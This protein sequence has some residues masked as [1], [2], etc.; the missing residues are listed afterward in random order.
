MTQNTVPS[1]PPAREANVERLKMAD[2]PLYLGIFI[3]VAIGL[4]IQA[5]F[6]ATTSLKELYTLSTLR[7]TEDHELAE[8]DCLHL[9][10]RLREKIDKYE[11]DSLVNH[12][13]QVYAC[14]VREEKTYVIDL[15]KYAHTV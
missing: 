10:P 12:D 5:Y 4:I 3:F 9:H 13:G 8:I 1:A 15:A 2:S 11:T 6:A 7:N 14:I